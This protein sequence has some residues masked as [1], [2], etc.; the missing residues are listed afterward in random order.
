[1]KHKVKLLKEWKGHA[2]GTVLEVDAESYKE[3][4]DGEMA[5]DV[6]EPEKSAGDFAAIQKGMIEKA[7]GAAVEAV[8]AKL[9][10]L[11]SDSTKMIHI[12]VKDRSDDDPCHGYLPGNTKSLK[13]ISPQEVNYAFGNFAAD[14]LH[15]TKGREPER[16]MKS[17]ERSEGVLRKAAGD[18]MIVSSD[19]DG[20]YLIFSAASQMI[21]TAALENAIVR[22]RARKI[23][24][25]TQLLRLPYL[26]D[27]S[28]SSGTVYGGINVFFDDELDSY[29]ASKPKLAQIELKLKKITALGY[30]SDEWVK[31][32]PV[33][34]GSW[35]IPKFGE[36]IGFKEDLTFLAGPGG[37]QP[38]GLLNSPSSIS[39]A[40]ETDQD[41]GTFVTENSAAMYAR[42]RVKNDGAV[43][44]L[45]NR[46]VF[47]QLPMFNI[48][49]G[50]GGS[51][52]FVNN[53][54]GKPG[55]TLWGYPIVYTEKVPALGTLGCITLADMSD[56]LIAD[57]QS[58]P[59]VA[60]SIHLKF[61]YGQT[62]FRLT[63]YIDGQ[64]ETDT[65]FQG[66]YGDTL[67]PVVKLAAS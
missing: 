19:T 43:C 52:V 47:P 36:A 40:L 61:E 45:M 55:Q 48:T 21:Q 20:G 38:L 50:T 18:G 65:A 57:D 2:I 10:E 26:R 35:L 9:K 46:S 17:R 66:V 6:K 1:M 53:V 67:S 25:A 37:A 23:S 13:D 44:W 3:L 54:A 22:P 42:L 16:L 31:W 12:S 59:E 62:A 7:T 63:K 56:Y 32:S 29:T 28:H 34:M 39:I 5:E 51:P 64:N 60:Q 11:A 8:E 58:G 24:M 27:V 41:A 49:A 14:V 33:T 15:A 30:V 4:K